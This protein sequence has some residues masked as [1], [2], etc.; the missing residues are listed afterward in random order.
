MCPVKA[1]LGM[2]LNGYFDLEGLAMIDAYKMTYKE[3]ENGKEV[4]TYNGY[5]VPNGF[6]I[7]IVDNGT[8]DAIFLEATDGLPIEIDIEDFILRIV[9]SGERYLTAPLEN[10]LNTWTDKMKSLKEIGESFKYDASVVPYNET[11]EYSLEMTK[12]EVPTINPQKSCEGLTDKGKALVKIYGKAL[13]EEGGTNSRGWQCEAP[14]KLIGEAFSKTLKRL[15]ADVG[16]FNLECK[17]G[18]DEVWV[19]IEVTNMEVL[20]NILVD[21]FKCKIDD[22][23]I[24]ECVY[25]GKD[26][27]LKYKY[28]LHLYN[29]VNTP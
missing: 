26:A 20:K 7:D 19:D 3:Y 24:A 5:A 10:T 17:C 11:V 9:F 8:Y 16:L 29:S 6:P 14:L 21:V 2:V 27:P 13:L 4:Y 25:G 18:T 28:T 15:Y 12:C 22:V 1:R 23:L